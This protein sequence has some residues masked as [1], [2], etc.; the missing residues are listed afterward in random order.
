M[1]TPQM[2]A[3]TCRER[4]LR[5]PDPHRDE[6]YM[7]YWVPD[8]AN[9]G[10]TPNSYVTGWTPAQQYPDYQMLGKGAVNPPNINSNGQV[11]YARK[12]TYFELPP[13]PI[14]RLPT[15]TLYV[16]FRVYP[17][18]NAGIDGLPPAGKTQDLFSVATASISY[19]NL[20]FISNGSNMDLEFTYLDGGAGEQ[21]LTITDACSRT[22]WA[23]VR[24]FY[25]D[26]IVT[27][28]CNSKVAMSDEP[29]PMLSIPVDAKGY[30]FRGGLGQDPNRQD[31]YSTFTN[32]GIGDSL[33]NPPP[34][35]S[36]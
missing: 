11:I 22:G 2:L 27:L 28:Q 6:D 21:V 24:L 14:F 30:V 10:Y 25:V 19:M 23:L 3:A 4:N 16:R 5:V 26:G 20:R 34:E 33:E 29:I 15:D 12:D 18:G 36:D 17:V 13:H 35:P 32:F 7:S 31:Q 1:I 8:L 9:Q